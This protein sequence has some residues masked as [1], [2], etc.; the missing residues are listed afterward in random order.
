MGQYR[1]GVNSRT[2]PSSNVR[3]SRLRTEGLTFEQEGTQPR[4]DTPGFFVILNMFPLSFDGAPNHP[5]CSVGMVQSVGV[6]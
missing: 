5:Y 4:L 2:T 1:P 6:A 3:N